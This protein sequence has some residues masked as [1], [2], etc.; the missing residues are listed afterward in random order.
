MRVRPTSPM[1]MNVCVLPA[2]YLDPNRDLKSL[3]ARIISKSGVV[4][5]SEKRLHGVVPAQCECQPTLQ[6]CSPNPPPFSK[7][8]KRA[9]SGQ[10]I[11]SLT[12]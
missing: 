4:T 10:W 11:V 6:K 1:G 12:Q 7:V 9:K 5:L 3:D 8:P 2:G